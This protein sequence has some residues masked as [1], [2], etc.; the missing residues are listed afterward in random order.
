M[1]AWQKEIVFLGLF[2]LLLGAYSLPWIIT[3]V[4]SLSLNAY[5]L[6]EWSS[7]HPVV[8][9]AAPPLLLTFGLRFLLVLACLLFVLWPRS[10]RASSGMRLFV[11][12]LGTAALLPP[13]EFFGESF[14]DPNYQQQAALALFL[15]IFSILILTQRLKRWHRV[16]QIGVCLTGVVVSGI[17]L[18]ASMT[19]M[20]ELWIKASVGLGSGLFVICLGVILV[21]VTTKRGNFIQVTS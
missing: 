15:M 6:A 9:T 19:L 16:L 21:L 3:P 10:G 12:L 8:R 4:T 5:D 1:R 13:F 17:T 18:A 7:L 14:D 11:S 20:R 2:A